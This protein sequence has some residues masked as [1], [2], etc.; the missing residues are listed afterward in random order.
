MVFKKIRRCRGRKRGNK[1]QRERGIDISRRFKALASD[2]RTYKS[3]LQSKRKRLLGDIRFWKDAE[4][5]NGPI[6]DEQRNSEKKQLKLNTIQY[7]LKT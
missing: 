3:R 5:R 4:N 2:G 1:G 6:M 7:N